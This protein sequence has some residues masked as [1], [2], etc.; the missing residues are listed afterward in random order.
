[1]VSP[2][3]ALGS[4]RFLFRYVRRRWI[5]HLVVLGS[6]LA[7]VGCAIG[8]Q[9]GVK[10]LVDVLGT[11]NP[12]NAALWSAAGLLLGLVAG[13][14]LLWRL[15]GWVATYG[16]VSVGR[17]LR[18]D[19]FDHLSG[20]GTRYFTD[21]FPGA[22]AAR[23][24]TAGNAAWSIEN[25]LT[26]T[27]IPPATAVVSSI[28]LLALINWHM[29][30]VL[31]F[32]IAILG[33][34]IA[35]LAAR[36][37]HLHE[38]FASQA[39]AVTGDLSDI[40]SN[41]GIVRACGTARR[42]Q[43]R[44]LDHIQTEVS[45][46]RESLFALERLRLFHAFSVFLVTAGVLAWALLL[47]QAKLVTTGDV[48]LA[49]TLCF[50][51]LHASRDL[52]MAIVELTQHFAKLNEAVQE[53]GLRHEMEDVPGAQPLVRLG[54]S[55][56]LTNVSFSY[57]NGERV[58]KEFNLHIP[59][60][61]KVGLVGRSGA[62]KTTILALIQRLYDPELGS[63][64]VDE[65][66]V[67][68]ITQES[69]RQSIAVVQQDISLFH[70]SLLENLRYGNLEATDEQVRDAAE[71]AQCSEFIRRLPEGFDTIIGE[72]GT[73]L[74]GGQRQRLAIAR[75]FLRAA[76]IILLDEATSALD[77]ESEF[78]IQEALVRLIKG[79]T[80]V[81]IAHRLSTL[82]AFDR[83]VMIDRGRIVEDGSLP[84]LQ[85]QKGF[86]SQIYERQFFKNR[87][88]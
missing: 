72:R 68:K 80:V 74:S 24:T 37:R 81:A 55:I 43:S 39:A 32:I 69:L 70:R 29:T 27:T 18:L 21:R 75:A 17:D 11:V 14:N 9:Y 57:P 47:W 79:R 10:S 85:R 3:F 33:A 15:A 45:A 23:V 62:G 25:L 49:T 7:A 5:T 35:G 16:F 22:L 12:S 84:D 40:V 64:L 28:A 88:L 31:F 87:K 52:A 4:V 34:V 20:H 73:K 60:G 86:F 82:E 44:L 13:D 50:T 8:S 58:L 59:S 66:D 48:V 36:T 6:V 67:R 53:I 63:V 2:D 78:A 30:A 46:Q 76:P 38:R 41:I 71:R 54:G 1:M 77:S 51:V 61:Q 19:L 42:E 56:A 65:Q 26:W 83:I